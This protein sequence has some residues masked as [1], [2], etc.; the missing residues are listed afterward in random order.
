MVLS[1]I[2]ICKIE[3]SFK[4]SKHLQ[5]V[6]DLRFIWLIREVNMAPTDLNRNLF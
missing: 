2:D 3:L 1:I 4:E 5:I 6:I